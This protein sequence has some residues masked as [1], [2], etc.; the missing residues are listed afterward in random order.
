MNKSSKTLIAGPWVGE[1][2]WELFAWQGYIRALSRNFNKA[3][4]ISR[5]ESK[6]LYKDFADTFVEFTPPKANAD[7]FFLQNINTLELFKQVV[8]EN[9]LELNSDKVLC[10][11]RRIGFPPHTHFDQAVPI[12]GFEVKPE[13]IRFGKLAKKK[14]KYILHARDRDFRKED[15]W[16]PN[17]WSTLIELLGDGNIAC[18]GTQNGSGYI[19]G[20]EDLRGIPLSNLLDILHNADC[21]FGPSS[22]PIHLSSLCGCP[23]V[24]WGDPS[25]SL[26][27]HNKNWNPLSTP[28]LFVGEHL[29]HPS[30]EHVF[31]KYKEWNDD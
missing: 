8:E 23:H 15:N 6:A 19:P 17:N 30:P 29:Y 20:T 2:G 25:K 16:N 28:S 26:G 24:V 27:R 4:V 31:K 3:I 14:Y 11:P 13:Y 9:N 7:S 22:G 21:I 12:G 5:P 1:F 18:I 10:L